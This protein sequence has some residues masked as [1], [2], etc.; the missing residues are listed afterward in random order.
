MYL[1]LRLFLC[2]P[3]PFVFLAFKLFGFVIEDV[4]GGFAV[5]R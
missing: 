1:V 3:D 5:A 4:V 2:V